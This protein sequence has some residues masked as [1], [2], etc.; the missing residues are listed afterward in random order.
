MR[1]S[2]AA[3]A[4]H[5]LNLTNLRLKVDPKIR[6]E[7][8]G[9]TGTEEGPPFDDARETNVGSVGDRVRLDGRS[10]RRGEGR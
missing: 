7:V 9:K 1:K 10:R 3:A 4:W 8:D 5:L 6:R 2:P